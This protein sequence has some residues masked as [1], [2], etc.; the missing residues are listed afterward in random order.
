MTTYTIKVDDMRLLVCAAKLRRYTHGR[1]CQM[2]AI[3]RGPVIHTDCSSARRRSMRESAMNM[4]RADSFVGPMH[5]GHLAELVLR[6][7]LNHGLSEVRKT[8]HTGLRALLDEP[9]HILNG[10][11]A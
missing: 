9:R 3:T 8:W 10:G 5:R 6:T 1:T 7:R 11:A 2:A 4:G